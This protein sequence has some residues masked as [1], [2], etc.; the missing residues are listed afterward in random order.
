MSEIVWECEWTFG[1]RLVRLRVRAWMRCK[2][3]CIPLYCC[4][5]KAK[6]LWCATE[7]VWWVSNAPSTFKAILT[8]V[9]NVVGG[10]L[11]LLEAIQVIRLI[12]YLSRIV[13]KR[14][15]DHPTLV[16]ACYS[17]IAIHTTMLTMP[18]EYLFDSVY[19]SL[20]HNCHHYF[21]CIYAPFSN[22]IFGKVQLLMTMT[23]ADSVI[24]M[25]MVMRMKANSFTHT[26]FSYTSVVCT[27]LV[28][29]TALT[30]YVEEG[31]LS[32]AAFLS[33][34]VAFILRNAALDLGNEHPELSDRYS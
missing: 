23:V 18:S 28:L 27:V 17:F 34:F 30:I 19:S 33:L 25:V 29:L 3:R 24:I 21:Q 12:M 5:D 31:I 26:C 20:P 11:L 32:D 16:K 15:E 14:V 1:V 6:A 10:I 9:P 2:G 7:L 8:R 22:S 13:V 4:F